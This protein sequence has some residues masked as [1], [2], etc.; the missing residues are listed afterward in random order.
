M[1]W[2]EVSSTIN[3]KVINRGWDHFECLQSINASDLVQLREKFPNED[4]AHL[5]IITPERKT[6]CWY[7][8]KSKDPNNPS[9]IEW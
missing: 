2:I 9:N 7:N 1:P 6:A 3:L 8:L 4:R 5:E